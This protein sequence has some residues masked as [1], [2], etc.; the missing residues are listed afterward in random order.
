MTT[1]EIEAKKLFAYGWALHG[2]AAKAARAVFPNDEAK[3]EFL[4][5]QYV[6]D[7]TVQHYVKEYERQRP[8][9]I[10]EFYGRMLIKLEDAFDA[11]PNPDTKADLAK[12]IFE[13]HAL[14]SAK[15]QAAEAS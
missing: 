9:D 15:R 1:A 12:L 10:V 8:L 4:M 14:W 6:D 2:S 3:V 11:C 5:S 7:K 13:Y